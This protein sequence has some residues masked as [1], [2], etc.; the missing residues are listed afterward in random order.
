MAHLEYRKR[1]KSNWVPVSY[2]GNEVAT[3]ISVAAGDMGGMGGPCVGRTRVV[4][5]GSGTAAIIEVGDGDDANGYLVD[6]NLD[7]TA[8]GLYWG[9][10][11]Y[12]GTAA[13]LYTVSDTI[14]ITFTANTA[15]TR[16]TGAIDLSVWVCKTLA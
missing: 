6:G 14:D 9:Q 7:E 12:Y 4:F 2:T 15:G 1:T 16:T 5:N 11:A 13:K 8:T 10:G 3:V